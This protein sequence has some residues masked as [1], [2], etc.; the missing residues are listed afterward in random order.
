MSSNTKSTKLA[1]SQSG[2]VAIFITMLIIIIISLIVLG[3]AQISR[4]NQR[5]TLDTQLST[6]AFYAAD[7]GVNDAFNEVQKKIVANV[8]PLPGKTTCGD[9]INYNFNGSGKSTLSSGVTYTCVLINP[10]PPSLTYKIGAQGV[11]IPLISGSVSPLQT[12][13]LTWTPEVGQEGVSTA[14]GCYASGNL[15]KFPN[16]SGPLAWGCKFAA[17]HTD[18]FYAAVL[19]RANWQPSTITNVL[20]PI[21]T[22]T[23]FPMPAATTDGQAWPAT[24]T[25][26][27]MTC[28]VT[29]TGLGPGTHY[30]R[31]SAIYRTTNLTITG[32]TATGP[33]TFSG[34]QVKIDV[35]GKAQDVL[36]RILVSLD[37]SDANSTV[38]S[39]AALSVADSV[40]KRFSVTSGSFN[41]EDYAGGN[42]NNL[43]Q[44]ANV[45]TPTP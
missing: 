21:N 9:D 41:N 15:G 44:A 19:S 22:A 7:S 32:T 28:R 30:M 5:N 37:L 36:R 40:C 3:F 38:K 24:C 18:L 4:R 26:V 2:M 27:P 11:V 25:D 45:G 43:C 20:E 34:S 17:L 12:I 14:A 31:V 6:Q 13:T 10:T 42:G 16:A 39:N 33:A 29:I 1:Q 35:T 23:N 8:V